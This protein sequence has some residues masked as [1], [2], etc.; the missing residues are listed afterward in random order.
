MNGG[1]DV[2]EVSDD[3]PLGAMTKALTIEPEVESVIEWHDQ[4]I[5]CA[6]DFDVAPEYA[7]T[8]VDLLLLLERFHPKPAFAW[9][10]HGGG[11]RMLYQAKEDFTAEE[12]G[13]V[14]LL[15]LSELR[16]S[17][18]LE[19]KHDTRHPKALDHSGKLCGEIYQRV[20]EF[21]ARAFR[22]RLRIFTATDDEA[23][24]WLEEHNMEVGGRYDHSSCP[25]APSDK[26][27]RRPVVVGDNGLTCYVCQANGTCV[28]GSKP[29]FF[30]FA[31]LCGA[32]RYST[33]YRCFENATHWE[34]ARLVIGDILGSMHFSQL[35]YSAGMVLFKGRATA[36]KCFVVGRDLVRMGDKWT[37]LSGEPYLK[38]LAPLLATLPACQFRADDGK[39]KIDRSRVVAFEQS[40]DLARYGYPSL[41]PV[42]GMKLWPLNGDATIHAVVQ[43]RE[44]STDAMASHRPQYVPADRRMPEE[45]M[46]KYFEECCPKLNRNLLMLLIAA[47]ATAEGGA[48]MPPIVFVTGPTGASKSLTSFMAASVCGDKNTEIVWTTESARIRQAII[49]AASTGTFVT[50]NEPLKE[51]RRQLKM[52]SFAMD[53]LLNLTPDSTSHYMYTGPVRMGRLPVFVCTDTDI[54]IELKQDAQLARR[55]I[56]ARLVDAVDWEIPLRNSGV[57]HPRRFRMSSVDRAA[58]A[59]ALLSLVV[60]LFFTPPT[61]FE[62]VAIALG[63]A[64]MAESSEAEEGRDH[65]RRLYETVCAAPP[66]DAKDAARWRG[67]GWKLINRDVDTPLREAWMQIAD[68]D[69]FH[70]SRAATEVDWRKVLGLRHSTRLEVRARG[71]R[72]VIRF[73]SATEDATNYLVNEELK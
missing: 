33:L 49:D 10:T 58:A 38:N 53:F 13:A 43:T 31:T 22:R 28:G 69:R 73:R 6:V 4:K 44:L 72:L 34:H 62:A 29:G 23:I 67:R 50:F 15:N 16:P 47:R 1:G 68:Q 59:N 27:G 60:D 42:F 3:D 30:P 52:H 12:I 11:L 57:L 55:V 71:N 14:A 5:L 54:P 24:R 40:F 48:S 9:V 37:N 51:A 19:L 20:Q 65:L 18:S 17:E 35:V 36:D 8:D 66:L 26:G 64:R 7:H 45:R 25:V 70:S 41:T 21:D 32:P 46:W 2:V 63:F 61:T 39:S 56:H